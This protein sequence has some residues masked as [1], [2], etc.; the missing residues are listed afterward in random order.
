VRLVRERFDGEA[1]GG[2]LPY[3]RS[4]GCQDR[5]WLVAVVLLG[6][7]VYVRAEP[8]VF[9]SWSSV[10]DLNRERSGLTATRAR[11]AGTVMALPV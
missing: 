5:V 10:I 1:P 3:R 2:S 4:A 7:S 8:D 11:T 9:A 6:V